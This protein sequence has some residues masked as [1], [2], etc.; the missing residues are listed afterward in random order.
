MQI[1][2]SRL[3]TLAAIAGVD[4]SGGADRDGSAGRFLQVRHV[5][6]HGMPANMQ[7]EQNTCCMA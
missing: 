4:D 7:K 2:V 3:N 6:A 1:G 5:I